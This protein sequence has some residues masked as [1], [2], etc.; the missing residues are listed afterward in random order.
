MELRQ[1]RHEYRALSHVA[2]RKSGEM[3]AAVG[4]VA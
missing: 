3:G 4:H 2:V 1:R